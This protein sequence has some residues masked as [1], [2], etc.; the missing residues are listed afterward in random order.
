VS[1]SRL[2]S[3]IVAPLRLD[4]KDRGKHAVAEARRLAS[5]HGID[6]FIVFG[7]DRATLPEIVRSLEEAARGPVL[8]MSDLERGCGQQIAGT[9]ELP[10]AMAIAATGSTQIAERCGALTAREAA[11]LG[12][13]V[14]LA[15]V[16]DVNVNP[17]N[18]IINTRAFGGDAD[19]VSTFANAFAAGVRRGGGIATA[20]HFPG[21]GDTSRDSHLETP[22]V[23]ANEETMRSVHLKP[24]DAAIRAG[25]EA[26][27]VGHLAVPALDRGKTRA[28]TASADVVG[29]W[30]RR[31]LGFRRVVMTD[32]LVMRGAGF[33]GESS[34]AALEAGC[35]L[36]LYPSDAEGALVSLERAE[37]S[38]RLNLA[39]L[40]ESQ[41]RIAEMRRLASREPEAPAEDG[42]ALARE[43]AEAAITLVGD[44]KGVLPIRGRD[45]RGLELVIVED[46]AGSRAAAFEEA[47]RK[48]FPSI[49][50]RTLQAREVAVLRAPAGLRVVAG[51]GSPRGFRPE[52]P[53]IPPPST[54]GHV[55]A[56]FGSPYLFGSR[57]PN[58]AFLCAYGDAPFLAE[59]AARAI[60]GDIEI[61][62]RL[63]VSFAEP[64]LA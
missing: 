18:P 41:D 26:I 39:R 24:F 23:T 14:V 56:S 13:R 1:P 33:G 17:R 64:A 34:V 49:V 51:F 10:P 6:S 12:I 25:V 8:L 9:T 21:H 3:L 35:D 63:P 45:A 55:L 4:E 53:P 5:E 43:T 50:C 7:G 22:V 11:A 42:E 44:S 48:R 28:A 16:V 20:K 61:R 52:I 15:P 59:A 58:A 62:G 36:A 32:A 29:D 46:A 47:M 2:A 38:G 40:D 31:K 30:L 54:P 57:R 19:R 37:R 60:S 27:M